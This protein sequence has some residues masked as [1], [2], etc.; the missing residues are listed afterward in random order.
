MVKTA[1]RSGF[2]LLLTAYSAAAQTPTGYVSL[3]GDYFPNRRDAA[4]L[5]G[6]IFVEEKLEPSTRIAINLAGF[7]EGLLARRATI[8]EPRSV[9]DAIVRIQEASVALS[10]RRAD[11]L[12]GFA[13]VTWGKLDEIQPTDVINPLDVSRFFFEGRS[14][15]RLPVLLVRGRFH[16]ND[17]AAI[18]GVYVPDFRSGRFDRLDEPSSPFN[19]PLAIAG[20]PFVVD[21]RDDRKPAFTAR[22]AQGGA[23]LSATS[24]TV[25]WSVSAYRGFE[26]FGLYEIDPASVPPLTIARVHP[27]FTMI[28]GDVEAVRGQWGLRGEVAVFVD[29][30]FQS[31][32]ARV[33]RGS[34]IDAGAGVDRRAAGATWSGTVLFHAESYERPLSAVNSDTERKD[35]TFVGSFDRTFSR[36]RYR[37]RGFAVYNANE[38]SAFLR[39]IAMASLRDN[40]ALEGSIGWFAGDGRDLVGRFGDSDFVYA[41]LKYYF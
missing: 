36:E 14:E 27:R 15:A 33:V 9:T 22:N 16:V 37:L 13:R 35:L 18:E 23:R 31:S 11:L 7:A 41:R 28:G 12:A 4:E 1:I 19:L 38:G 8:G 40:V 21:Q 30:N 25:D 5:R 29:D 32:D 34:S 10:G 26:S 20:T 24:G 6:R 3:F 2:L 17:D 39:T